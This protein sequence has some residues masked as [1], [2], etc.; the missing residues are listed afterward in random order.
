MSNGVRPSS[1]K[2]RHEEQEQSERLDDGVTDLRLGLIVDDLDD[3]EGLAEH[4]H[5][6]D[7]HDEGHLVADELSGCAQAPQDGVLVGG[8]PS[9]H[10]ESEHGQDGERGDVEEAQ[11]HVAE[12]DV[13]GHGNGDPQQEGRYEDG[14]RRQPVDAAVGPGRKNVLLGDELEGIGYGLECAVRPDAHGAHALLDTGKGFAF[15]PGE[16][17]HHD[18]KEG[19]DEDSAY[20]VGDW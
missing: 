19:E 15:E 18:G 6:E 14:Q 13:L 10:D 9:C 12:D 1:A 17:Q 16:H 3:V 7:G 11:V 2:G 5:G 8:T 4:R 20:G